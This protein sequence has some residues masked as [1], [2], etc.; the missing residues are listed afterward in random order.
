MSC[1]GACH[2]NNKSIEVVVI[3][4]GSSNHGAMAQPVTDQHLSIY[5]LHAA[6]REVS[7]IIWRRVLVRSGTTFAQLHD[8]LRLAFGWSGAHL[9]RFKVHAREV[10]WVSDSPSWRCRARSARDL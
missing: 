6:V 5:Q 8:V 9:H 2:Q 4:K 1:R 10:S 7:P 3:V